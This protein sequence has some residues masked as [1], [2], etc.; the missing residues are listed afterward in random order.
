MTVTLTGSSPLGN[1]QVNQNNQHA[2]Y[3]ISG[4]NATVTSTDLE[5]VTYLAPSVPITGTN[6]VIF[7][8]TLS[9]GKGGN[10]TTNVYA[11]VYTS[12]QAPVLSGTQSGQ[13][14]NDNT[15]HSPVL[16]RQHPDL[17]RDTGNGG[18][19]VRRRSNQ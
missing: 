10:Y 11:D 16:Q 7:T 8:I 19:S 14:V 17:Q 13:T 18:G 6:T 4:V 15:N 12:V 2:S 9:D 1:F 3:S 5:G